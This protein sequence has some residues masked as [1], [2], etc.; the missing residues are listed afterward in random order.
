MGELTYRIA[1]ESRTL[2]LFWPL[3][4]PVPAPLAGGSECHSILA[5]VCDDGG[6]FER[7]LADVIAVRLDKHLQSQGTF[8]IRRCAGDNDIVIII[9]VVRAICVVFLPLIS[10]ASHLIGGKPG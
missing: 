7:V 10:R 6:F 8:Q 9:P 2:H 4:C 1:S 5:V 3:R